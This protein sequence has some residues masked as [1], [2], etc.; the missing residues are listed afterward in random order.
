MKPRWGFWNQYLVGM[1]W[2]RWRLLRRENRIDPGY[3]HRAALLTLVSLH[4]SL[5]RRREE[6]EYGECIARTS[7]AGPPLFVLG[8]WRS[9]TTHLH[10]L[11]ACDREQ[12]AYPTS[13]QVTYPYTFLTCETAIRKQARGW[14][15]ATRPMDNVAIDLDTPQE[16]EFAMCASCLRSP[17]LGMFSFPRRMADYDRYLTFREARDDELQEWRD[18][19]QWFLR[20][21]TLRY[22][23]PL[24]L[25]SPPHTTRLRVLLSLFPNARFV[26]VHRHP[27]EV[28]QSTRHLYHALWPLHSLQ[29]PPSSIDQAILQ[30]YSQMYQAFFEEKAAIPTGRFCEVAFEELV[31]DPIRAL[32]AVYEQLGL[33]GFE[34]VLPRLNAHLASVGGFQRNRFE[35]LPVETREQVRHRWRESFETWGYSA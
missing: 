18:A 20:K 16:D 24:L 35:E 32:H 6:R 26:H 21:L 19:F 22:D 9:G 17:Y 13:L 31:R 10:N 11:L 30:R 27:Y 14:I 7:L 3:H 5:Q 4:N 29:R 28:F 1:P 33:P 25:K 15:P 8:H 2:E 34:R 12:F 23:R